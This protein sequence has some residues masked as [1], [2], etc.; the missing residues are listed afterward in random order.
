MLGYGDLQN[1]DYFNYKQEYLTHKVNYM[2]TF[3][4]IDHFEDCFL[5]NE[6]ISDYKKK[7]LITPSALMH[8]DQITSEKNWLY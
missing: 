4:D 7:D 2:D 3:V 8:E 5:E 6:N 1:E